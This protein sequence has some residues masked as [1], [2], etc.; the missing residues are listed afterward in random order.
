MKELDK[1]EKIRLEKVRIEAE[2]HN[3]VLLSQQ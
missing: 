2:K 1:K 3:R